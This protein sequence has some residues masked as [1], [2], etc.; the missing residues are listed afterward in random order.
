FNRCAKFQVYAASTASC[1][2][3]TWCNRSA[4]SIPIFPWSMLLV[5]RRI[6]SMGLKAWDFF[7]YAVV[8]RSSQSCS[9]ALTRTSDDRELKMSLQL[10]EWQRPQ[11]GHC[12]IVRQNSSV[13]HNYATNFGPEL[14]K[15]YPMPDRTPRTRCAWQTH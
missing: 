5:L 11:N 6:N 1:S 9:V 14:R 4:R 13:K 2:I 12:A 15:T 10:W 8:F 7:S 3:A